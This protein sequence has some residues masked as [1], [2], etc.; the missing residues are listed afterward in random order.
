ML[1]SDVLRSKG[2]EVLRVRPE[3]GVADAVRKLAERRIGAVVVEDRWMKMVGIFSE[4]D[5]LNAIARRG[6]EVLACPVSELMTA[7]V[8]TCRPAD[9]IDSVLGLMTL[10]RIR[11]LPVV[12]NGALVGIVSI[13]DLIKHRLDEKELEANVLLEISR[14]RA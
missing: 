7:P 6:A 10:R 11:H 13:G 1:I 2:H 9:R 4:R 3:D 5:L 8:V 12:D 14:M